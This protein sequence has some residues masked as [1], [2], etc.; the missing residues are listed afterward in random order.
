MRIR[1]TFI[2]LFINAIF[3]V[4]QENIAALGELPNSVSET[5][6]LLYFD[7]KL[8]TH[9]DSGNAAQLYEIDTVNLEVTRVV[10]VTNVEN[11]DWEDLAQDETYIYIGDFGNNVGTRTDLQIYRIAKAEFNASNEVNAERIRFSYEDQEDLTDN[12]NSDWDAEAFF[13]FNDQL[14]VLTKEWK[15]NQTTAY[16]I[17]KVP[18]SYEAQRIDQFN[19]DGLVTGASYN[20]LSNVLFIIGYSSILQPFVIRFE[21]VDTSDIFTENRERTILNIGLAQTEAITFVDERRIFVSSESFRSSNPP[22]D[23]KAQLFGFTTVALTPPPPPNPESEKKNI[24]LFQRP[25]FELL[26]YSLNT[27]APLR[28]RA[29]FDASGQRIRYVRAIDIAN[30]VDLSTLQNGIYYLTFYFEKEIV[31][32]PFIRN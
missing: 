3:L 17:P 16:S 18:G 7:G 30:E 4:S 11:I 1:L 21:D 32:I 23:L 24:E 10:R 19:V 26:E 9:N 25:N 13:V 20:T 2:L 6:G 14:I 28:A 12:G 29:I 27:D 8:V 31:A 5:S 15:R 22:L